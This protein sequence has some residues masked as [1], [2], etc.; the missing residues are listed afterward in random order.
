MILFSSP[1]TPNFSKGWEK[2]LVSQKSQ[3]ILS[4]EYHCFTCF[5]IYSIIF[6][7]IRQVR[8]VKILSPTVDWSTTTVE[9][10]FSS[11]LVFPGCSPSKF[12]NPWSHFKS[13]ND[14]TFNLCC[15]PAYLSKKIQTALIECYVLSANPEN[16]LFHLCQVET[17]RNI[18][19]KYQDICSLI[20]TSNE[21][22]AASYAH[23]LNHLTSASRSLFVFLNDLPIN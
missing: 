18:C 7:G 17:W 1:Q 20:T 12:Q 2:F 5:L 13:C 3:N 8:N 9:N 21:S 23:K 6:E 16:P 10:V 14:E 4:K 11:L 19:K 15:W 22:E